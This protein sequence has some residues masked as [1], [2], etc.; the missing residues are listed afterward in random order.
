VVDQ[1]KRP[2]RGLWRHKDRYYVQLTVEDPN[3]GVKRVKRVP[4]EEAKMDAQAVAKL[5]ELLTQRRKGSLPVL[6]RTPKFADYA[7]TYFDYYKQAVV[8]Q[9]ARV[10][11]QGAR[12][13][14]T[15][16]MKTS[17]LWAVQ[18]QPL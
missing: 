5:Q 6:K 10:W 3:T 2:N 17:H 8:K 12:R 13:D 16:R 7:Q 18:D 11:V 4:L 15:G 9:M 14:V 1:R